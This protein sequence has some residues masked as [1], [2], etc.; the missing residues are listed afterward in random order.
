[1]LRPNQPRAKIARLILR[2]L[3]LN[4]LGMALLSLIGPL[5]PD[6]QNPN[7]SFTS[8]IT[9]TIFLLYGLSGFGY[10]ALLIGSVVAFL[11]WLHRAYYNLHQLPARQPRYA[12]GWVVGAWFVPVFNL[13]RPYRIVREVW[14]RTQQAATGHV[15]APAT[16]LPW[17]WAALLLQAVV[18]R[19][20]GAS[21][22]A[23]SNHPVAQDVPLATV[24][25]ASTQLLAFALTRYVIGCCAQFE[26]RLASRQLLDQLGQPA[27]QAAP[28]SQPASP[29]WPDEEEY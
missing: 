14:Q 13:V 1:M 9:N 19:V 7:S 24:L 12:V 3:M 27:H 20:A 28:A 17:W 26:A 16:V 5:Q 23:F 4:T 10:Y 11:L 8:G 18:G 2:L 15:A 25:D 21:G 22:S 6:W 29:Y